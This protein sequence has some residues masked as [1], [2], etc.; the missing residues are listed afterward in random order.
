MGRTF[1]RRMFLYGMGGSALPIPFL[2][3]LLPR[4]AWGQSTVPIKRYFS[5]VGGYDYGHHQNWFP[6]LN[7]LPNVY[8]PGNGDHTIRYQPL[9]SFLATSNSD[10]SLILG[11]G[12]N[13]F[14]KKMN[15]LRGLNLMTRI[16]HGKGHVL[17]NIQGTDGHDAEV[18]KLKALPTIDQVLAAN[19]NFTPYDRDP[20]HI[21]ESYSFKK[22]PQGVVTSASSNWS[23]PHEIFNSLFN[24]GGSP[25]PE[26]GNTPTI[27]N[28]RQDI[29]SRVID[30]YKKV[31]N[32]RQISSGD[33]LILDNAMDR[34]SDIQA[35]LGMTQTA[36]GCRYSNIDVSI[37]KTDGIPNLY[38][39]NPE[40]NKYAYQMYAQIYAAAASCDLHRVFNF[41]TPIPDYFDRN[42]TEDFHQ[43]HS[44][45]P[46][47]A[48]ASNQGIINHRYMG[49]IWRIYVDSFLVPLLTSLDSISEGNGKTI[50]DNS[51]VHMT[52]E[53]ST[54]HNDAS[55]PCLLIG[56]A[57][58][59]LTTGHYI[60]YTRRD[61]GPHTHQGDEFNP[62]P[63]DPRFGHDYYGAHYNRSL[64]TILRALGLNPNEYED[65]QINTFFQGRTD[66]LIG[67]MNNGISRVGGYG[68]I[69][70]TLGG[71]GYSTQDLYRVQYSN[72]NFNFYKNSLPFPPSSA[73]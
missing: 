11:R 49:Q 37:S 41:H 53:S 10:M 25:I 5:I 33:Q 59:A 18:I 46:F 20:L 22:D 21:G 43:G 72:Y 64:T 13:P 55:R 40:S 26:N 2:S 6:T 17:G 63:A 57:A 73:A 44:H 69:G 1:S 7:Q 65:P 70:S 38:Y 35:R 45:K 19:R 12:L 51:L 50:L 67:S 47:E 58:G 27:V 28:P 31:R 16:A 68:H 36:A 66:S 56:G 15:L 62:N 24:I 23:K 34:I 48:I 3:S 8:N 30:D 32:G 4:S 61:L 42:A 52:L 54:V 60:D 29:L 14:V 71:G 39:Y 9:S